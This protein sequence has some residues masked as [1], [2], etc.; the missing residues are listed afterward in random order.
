M[1]ART[2]RSVLS[3]IGSRSRHISELARIGLIVTFH[4]LENKLIY[5]SRV[6]VF[7]VFKVSFFFHI[8]KVAGHKH[9]C[10]Y[11]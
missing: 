9:Y 5:L 11:T 1:K 6:V 8:T 10:L 4:A 7:H 2:F 3:F